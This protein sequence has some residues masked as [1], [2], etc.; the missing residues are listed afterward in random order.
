M[1]DMLSIEE[2]NLSLPCVTEETPFG[3]EVLVFKVLGKVFAL[4]SI[5]ERPYNMALKCDP[6]F[7]ILLRTQYECIIPAFHLNKK[8]WI[9][10]PIDNCPLDSLLVKRLIR[11]SYHCVCSKMSKR[12]RALHS[13]IVTIHE[14]PFEI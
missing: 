9:Q 6:D 8:H 13:E 12:Q 2:Y 5:D 3:P 1:V 14:E 4:I 11:H 7:S 10:F